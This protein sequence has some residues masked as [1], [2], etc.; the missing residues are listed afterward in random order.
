MTLDR[1]HYFINHTMEE[2]EKMTMGDFFRANRQYLVN[3]SAVRD[4]SQGLGRKLLINLTIPFTEK[5][6]VGKVKAN[7]FLSW[8]SDH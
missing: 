5:I 3:R 2:L 8:L 1:Q 6:S 7:S 4:V